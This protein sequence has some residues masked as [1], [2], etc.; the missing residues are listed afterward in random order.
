MGTS[1]RL[2]IVEDSA[3]DV[4]LLVRE[5]QRGGYQPVYQQVETAPAMQAALERQTWDLVV[6]DHSVL[7]FNSFAA[8]E[9]LK[10]SGLDIPFII[11]SGT[12]GEELAVQAMKAG[13]HDYVLKGNLKR[14]VPALT[15]ELADA[16]ERRAR[17]AA[18]RAL[19]EGQQQ[20]V[21]ELA[22]AY[23]ATIEGWARAL[24]LRDRETE[25]HSRRVTDL[26]LR[27]ARRLGVNEAEQVHLRR[28]ALLHDIGKMGVPDAVLLKPSALTPEEWEIMR[29]HPAYARE[30]LAPIAY[31]SP[32]LD[33]P[34]CHHEKWDGTGYPR[35]LRGEEIPLAARIFAAVDIWDA[36]R[37]DRPYRPAWSAERAQEHIASLAGTHLD[38]TVAQML[39]DML[40][41]VDNAS[42]AGEG[43]ADIAVG[44]MRGTILVVDDD[45]GI[46]SLLQR[47]LVGDGYVVVTADSGESALAAAAQHHLDLVL[48]DIA[49]PQPDGLVVCRRLKDDPATR[50]IPIIFMTGRQ[51]LDDETGLRD[52]EP[53]DYLRKPVD[54]HEIRIR[55]RRVLQRVRRTAPDERFGHP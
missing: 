38:P 9:L 42:Q 14:L 36:V 8:L 52:V 29:R 47:W 24:D 48:L 53:D 51:D 3:D 5:L 12:I 43:E 28:G 32:A 25:G 23:E 15:R 16:E 26:T 46:R 50:R 21:L 11:V 2:L 20:T 7:Q 4:D 18:E 44:Q 39:L 55:I 34:Y 13:A 30:L 41:S 35:G 27:L 17:R 10:A 40:A 49:M 45:D 31:L 1:L 37:S 22:T 6:S 33:I 19:R 54:G